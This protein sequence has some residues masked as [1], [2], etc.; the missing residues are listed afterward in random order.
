MSDQSQSD[1]FKAAMP[2]IPGVSSG[3]ARTP[4]FAQNPAVR[5]VAGLLIVLVLCF[6][7]ARW[8]RHSKRTEAVAPTAPAQIEVPA[9]AADSVPAIPRA[10]ASNPEIATVTEMAKPWTSKEFSFVDHFS[11]ESSPALLI[12]LPSGSA[13]QPE[14]YWAL[15]MKAPYGSCRLEYVADVAKLREQYEFNGAR[16]PM[17]GDPCSRT[18]FDP[19]KMSNIPPDIWVRGSIAQGS[20]LRPPLGIEIQIRGKEILA[21]KME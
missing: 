20:D 19:L 1:K 11:S 7:A 6:A 18:V 10:T 15:S 17:V 2:N 12:R 21:V 14:G 5:L 9:P 16:H 3:P 13:S 4:Q 8:L